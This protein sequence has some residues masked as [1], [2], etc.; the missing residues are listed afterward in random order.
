MSAPASKNYWKPLIVCSHAA[1]SRLTVAALRE[2]ELEDPVILSEYPRPGTMASIAA[3]H[4]VNICFLDVHSNQ[5]EALLLISEAASVMP[6]VALNPENDADLILRCLRRGACEFLCDGGAE[7]LRG[8]LERLNRLRAPALE[9]KHA[10][11]YCAVPGKPGCGASTLAVHLAV[12]LKRAGLKRVLLVDADYL[13]ASVGFLLRLK[14]DFHLDDAIRD[15]MRLDEDFWRN[16]VVSAQ[17]IDVLT[18]PEQAAS[19]V[20]LDRPAAVELVCFWREHYDAVVLDTPGVQE[21]GATLASLSDEILLITTN[22]LCPLHTTKRSLELLRQGGVEANRIKL[23]LTR[24]TPATGLKSDD[25]KTAL[26]M[27]PFALLQNDYETLQTAVLEGRPAPPASRFAR[28]VHDLVIQ[29]QGKQPVAR[30]GGDP[31]P[32]PKK[33]SLRLNWF[34][35]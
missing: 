7:Q 35:R 33:S 3:Q 26:K 24:Y 27:S 17:G 32:A 11:V 18:A 14:S 1:M 30:N 4:Q 23:L 6:V 28:S 29:L 31:K 16:L 10:T 5:E 2:L 21:P 19:P 13:S 20:M 15:C 25:L 22:E 34:S 9:Q 12:E 8:L